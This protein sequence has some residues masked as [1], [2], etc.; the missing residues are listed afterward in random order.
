MICLDTQAWIWWVTG[1][2]ELP[3]AV[4]RVIETDQL[5][6]SD[7]SFWETAQLVA[8]G[9]IRLNREV[10]EFLSEASTWEGLTVASITPAIAVRASRLGPLFPKDPMDRLI[11]ATAL[12]LRAT[13]VTSDG[14]IR[15]SG[16]VPVLWD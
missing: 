1:F 4:R 11:T 9:R 2:R 7:V 14:R 8:E 16:V 12:E 13:L 10:V 15:S 6:V 3:V 5:V